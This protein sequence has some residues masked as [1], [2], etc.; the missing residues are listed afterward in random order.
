MRSR[1]KGL[2]VILT[3]VALATCIALGVMPGQVANAATTASITVTAAPAFIG[4]ANSASTW[5]IN[6][7]NSG[8]GKIFP[9]TT[10][11]ANPLGGTTSPTSGGAED[12]E[13][14]WTITNTSTI[15]TDL[16]VTWSD[17]TSGD[18]MTNANSASAGATSFGAKSYFSGQASGA[19]VVA[20]SSGSSVGYSN[21]AAT[22][23]KKWG[24]VI[25]TQTSAWA[26]SSSMSSTVTVTASAH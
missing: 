7:E 13:C 22:T 11:Y 26:S 24:L 25:S 5:T 12:G 9:S 16:T 20:K 15:A 8:P 3:M 23:D 19:W 6:S 1:S 10:Y 17:M 4:I 2:S 18:A 21:L 14:D